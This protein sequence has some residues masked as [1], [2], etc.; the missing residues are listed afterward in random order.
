[1]TARPTEGTGKRSRPSRAEHSTAANSIRAWW[2][3]TPNWCWRWQRRIWHLQ[4]QQHLL[5]LHLPTSSPL[6][7]PLHLVV[8]LPF[9]ISPYRPPL[10][11]SFGSFVRSSLTEDHRLISIEEDVCRDNIWRQTNRHTQRN[12]DTCL[13]THKGTHT[14]RHTGK[15]VNIR[16]DNT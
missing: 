8:G 13:V 9:H 11:D 12:T 14:R 6:R 5:N 2:I 16:A 1:M 10:P 4:Q 3:R 7:C 15:L